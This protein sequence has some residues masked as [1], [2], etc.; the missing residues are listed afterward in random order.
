[1]RRIVVIDDE[2]GVVLKEYAVTRE[3]VKM[4]QDGHF[5]K[6]YRR[7]FLRL[8]NLSP[9]AAKAFVSILGYVSRGNELIINGRQFKLRDLEEVAGLSKATAQAA[10]AELKEHNII[11]SSN[12]KLYANPNFVFCGVMYD[13]SVAALFSEGQ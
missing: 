6:V 9:K 7:T 8:R 13:T 2:T 11:K 12:G 3:K 5:I 10:F 1:M 4:R